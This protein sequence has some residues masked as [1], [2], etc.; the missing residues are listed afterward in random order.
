VLVTK[1]H[2]CYNLLPCHLNPLVFDLE[3]DKHDD[4]IAF[5]RQ[6]NMEV[7]LDQ[8]VPRIYYLR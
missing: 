5:G 4:Y 8:W 6:H 3:P 1:C 7:Q 2:L